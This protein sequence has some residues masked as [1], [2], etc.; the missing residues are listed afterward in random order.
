MARDY[1][2]RHAR[3]VSAVYLC[4]HVEQMAATLRLRGIDVANWKEGGIKGFRRQAAQ[5]RAQI[6]ILERAI[7][8][9]AS[10][11][12]PEVVARGPNLSRLDRLGRAQD[13]YG[14]PAAWPTSGDP[15]FQ[16]LERSILGIGPAPRAVRM[17]G[18]GDP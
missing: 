2:P 12:A 11:A 14:P 9:Q 7:E 3:V 13:T 1:D 6:D 15:D 16:D 4:G 10:A 5:L 17:P 8:Q 18:A